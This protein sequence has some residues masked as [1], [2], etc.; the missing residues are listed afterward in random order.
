MAADHNVLAGISTR[1]GDSASA[2][3]HHEEGLAIARELGDASMIALL[4]GNLGSSVA[5]QGDLERGRAMLEESLDIAR[6][7]LDRKLIAVYLFELAWLAMRR[8]DGAAAERLIEESLAV[9]RRIGAPPRMAAV[10][11]LFAFLKSRQGDYAAA[12]ASVPGASCPQAGRRRC[13]DGC[14]RDAAAGLGIAGG[15]GGVC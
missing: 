1:E 4:L 3:T 5:A 11:S 8:G 10:L 7:I 9:H 12:T 13:A 14:S 2:R 6:R 15:L